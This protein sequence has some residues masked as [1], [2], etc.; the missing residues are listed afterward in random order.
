MDDPGYVLSKQ[1]YKIIREVV[2]IVKAWH[3]G[4]MARRPQDQ[5]Q[6]RVQGKLDG[7][8]AKAGAFEDDPATAS[9]SIWSKN[10]SGEMVD[11]GRNITVVNR[12]MEVEVLPA[13][14][15]GKAEWI[16]GEWQMYDSDCGVP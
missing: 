5:Q 8:L 16:D 13:L 7:E 3:R 12:Y 9:F 15:P 6:R 10:S 11:S 1:T 2:R 14:T 4:E